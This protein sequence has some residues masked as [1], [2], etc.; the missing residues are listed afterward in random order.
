MKKFLRGHDKSRAVLIA[1]LAVSTAFNVIALR[2]ALH[3]DE[4]LRSALHQN[5]AYVKEVGRLCSQDITFQLE[6]DGPWLECE[7]KD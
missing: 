7:K 1:L 6:V 2:S 3:D 4:A 5:E